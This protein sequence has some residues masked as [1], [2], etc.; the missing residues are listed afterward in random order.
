MEEKELKSGKGST[1]RN[2][3][4]KLDKAKSLGMRE[5]LRRIG[6]AIVTYG[7]GVIVGVNIV[8]YLNTTFYTPTGNV[9]RVVIALLA[10]TITLAWW[11]R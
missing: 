4:S 2:I 6:I 3:T 11:Y 7:L 9:V 8:D 1:E 5:S 10:G